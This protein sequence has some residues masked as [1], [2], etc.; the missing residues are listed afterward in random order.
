VSRN[1]ANVTEYGVLTITRG[2][3]DYKSLG[4]SSRMR[5]FVRMDFEPG[6]KKQYQVEWLFRLVQ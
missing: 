3:A 6:A 2:P 5:N 1:I 4:R